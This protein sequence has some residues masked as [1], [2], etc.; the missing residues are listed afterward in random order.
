MPLMIIYL[1]DKEDKIINKYV[2]KFKKSK[3]DIVKAIIRGD[4]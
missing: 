3:Q 4:I 1:D 2:E